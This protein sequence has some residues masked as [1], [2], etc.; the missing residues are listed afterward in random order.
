MQ[1][2]NSLLC[3]SALAVA[4]AAYSFPKDL[5]DGNYSVF[6]KDGQEWHVH[7]DSEPGVTLEPN[8]AASYTFPEDL[9]DGAYNVVISSGTDVS[10]NLEEPTATLHRDL[11]S[12]L[13]GTKSFRVRDNSKRQQW[14]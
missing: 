1:F 14:W 10:V 6:V 9:A 3:V 11:S 12:S 2:R 5:P 7:L 4:A 8:P 13:S